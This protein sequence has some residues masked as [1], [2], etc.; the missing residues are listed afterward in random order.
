MFHTKIYLPFFPPGTRK[1]LS[2]KWPFF[3]PFQDPQLNVGIF[4]LGAGCR[5]APYRPL[6]EIELHRNSQLV[7][8]LLFSLSYFIGKNEEALLYY[9]YHLQA[10]RQQNANCYVN[11]M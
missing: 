6:G 3:G 4:I 1:Y 7:F 9:P 11:F 8:S 2:L 10:D 5:L